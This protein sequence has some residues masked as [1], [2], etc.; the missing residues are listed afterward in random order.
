LQL[1]SS[2]LEREVVLLQN[3]G[4]MEKLRSVVGLHDMGEHE[5]M[6]QHACRQDPSWQVLR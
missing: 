3:Q 4:N 2:F 1:P 5:N 6:A